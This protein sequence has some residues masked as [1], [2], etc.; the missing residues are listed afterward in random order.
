CSSCSTVARSYAA[1]TGDAACCCL[2]VT[3]ALALPAEQYTKQVAN[4]ST[5]RPRVYCTSIGVSCCAFAD[6]GTRPRAGGGSASSTPRLG[7]CARND[8]TAGA[9][10]R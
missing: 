8:W 1:R 10:P 7:A 5:A 4:V 2:V 3:L 9:H 6:S